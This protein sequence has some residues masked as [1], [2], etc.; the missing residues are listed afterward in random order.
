MESEVEHEVVADLRAGCGGP[1]SEMELE[2]M[3]DPGLGAAAG[4]AEQDLGKEK[5][6]WW[7]TGHR[8]ACPGRLQL[9]IT[10]PTV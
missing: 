2:A 5:K 3:A 8:A 6:A 7:L 9:R 10:K 1:R 4:G